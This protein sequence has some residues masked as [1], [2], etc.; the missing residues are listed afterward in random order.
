[1][2]QLMLVNPKRRKKARKLSAAQRAA[3]FG[4]G[5]RRKRRSR[6]RATV[7]AHA[8][9]KRRR[10]GA[11][12]RRRLH[13]N[14]KGGGRGLIASAKSSLMGSLMPAAL[15]GAG[16]LAVD[17]A[18]GFAPIP[19]GLKSGPAAPLVKIAGAVALGAAVSKFANKRFG[20]AILAGYL[21]VTAYSMVKGFIAKMVPTLP[22]SGGYP[23]D[24]G[25]AQAG[26]FIPD[27]SGVSAYLGAPEGY[28][29]VADAS[30]PDGMGSYLNGYGDDVS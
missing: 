4:G 22:L 5:R 24:L 25:Y 29:V 9:P 14:P 23:Y 21:T 8:N 13:R 10:S 17:V 18:W 28:D 27:E 26:A 15:G 11:R 2:G 19:A 12:R 1:M 7:T 6:R 30:A 3:G 20:Q 16:A